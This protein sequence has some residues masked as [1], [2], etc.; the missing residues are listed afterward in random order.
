MHCQYKKKSM[1]ER[2]YM[3]V[4][5]CFTIKKKKEN[6]DNYYDVISYELSNLVPLHKITYLEI[7]GNDLFG[8]LF[9]HQ[10]IKRQSFYL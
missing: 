6:F 7:F 10:V 2:N 3:D 9:F 4:F 5:F 1:L 8:L